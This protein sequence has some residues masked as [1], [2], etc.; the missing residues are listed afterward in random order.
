M[1]VTMTH[2]RHH[3]I[4]ST[5]FPE[6]TL[7]RAISRMGFIQADPIRSPARAQDLIL[8]HRVK[9]YRAGDLDRRYG[10]LQLEEDYLYAY[11]FVPL[12]TWK[13]LHPRGQRA[14]SSAEQKV[15]SLVT[16]KKPLHP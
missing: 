16:N 13:L 11:G 4:A 12:S 6:P 5:L 10:A 14:L 8:R 9:Q 3:A 2:L 15:L 1:K 7:G